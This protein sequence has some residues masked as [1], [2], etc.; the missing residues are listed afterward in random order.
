MNTTLAQISFLELLSINGHEAAKWQSWFEHQPSSLLDLPLDIAATKNVRELVR[1]IFGVEL[2]N[3]QRLVGREIVQY[4][5]LP[6]DTVARLFGVGAEAR[7]LYRDYLATATDADLA[8]VLEFPTR[9]GVVR[10][11]KRKVVLNGLLHGSRHWAQ[12]ATALRHAGHPTDWPHDL[13]FTDAIA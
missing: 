5:A 6:M 13:L 3:A 7:S 1:H 4:D 12:L 2:R 11:S 10:A 9:G 8:T